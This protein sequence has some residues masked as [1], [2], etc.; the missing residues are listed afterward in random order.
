M[1]QRVSLMNVSQRLLMQI[2]RMKISTGCCLIY[3]LETL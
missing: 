2:N 3:I 1:D